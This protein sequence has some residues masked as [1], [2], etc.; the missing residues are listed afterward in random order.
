[1]TDDK[2]RDDFLLSVVIPVYNE[3]DTIHEVMRRVRATPYRKEIILVDDMSTDGTRDLLEEFRGDDVRIHYHAKNTGKGGALRTG[4]EEA[5]GDV[6]LIQ[7][8]DLEYDPSDYP[9]LLG[10]ILDGRADAVFGSRFLGGPHRVMLFWHRLGN[11]LLTLLSNMMTNL[12]LT[13]METGYKVF[14]GDVI[15][16]IRIQCNRFGVEPELTA[17][18]ARM[19]ARIYETPISYSGRD[20]AQ[21][22]KITWRDGVAALWHIFRFRFFD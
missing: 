1:M 17:K 2:P 10:P 21:G 9:T 16:R 11:S 14:R 3:R 6:V 8:A 18:L 4:I 13:D 22:K 7:D 20:Y 19:R 12:D 5:R 15:R